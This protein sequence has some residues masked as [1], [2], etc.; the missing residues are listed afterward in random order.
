MDRRESL[1]IMTAVLAHGAFGGVAAAA[2]WG[3]ESSFLPAKLNQSQTNRAQRYARYEKL[4]TEKQFQEFRDDHMMS[5]IGM[6]LFN[7]LGLKTQHEYNHFSPF[8]CGCIAMETALYGDVFAEIVKPGFGTEGVC[9]ILPPATIYRIET[10]K[11]ELIEFQQSREGPDYAA[12]ARCKVEDAQGEQDRVHADDKNQSLVVAYNGPIALP[13]NQSCAIRFRVDDIVHI[14]PKLYKYA[15]YGTSSLET[16]K[17]HLD[18]SWYNDTLDGMKE[19][20]KRLRS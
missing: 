20:L 13:K 5:G 19:I 16:G 2:A 1:K 7:E 15:P 8:R 3:G 9:V 4:A 18:P 12:I 11:G 10:I 17:P 6:R 14:R